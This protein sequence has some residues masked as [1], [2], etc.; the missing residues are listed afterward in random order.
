[1]SVD[2][3]LAL[4]YLKLKEWCPKYTIKYTTY[5][6]INYKNLQYRIY[7]NKSDDQLLL[8]KQIHDSIDILLEFLQ[9]NNIDYN[10]R[11][12]DPYISIESYYYKKTY[13]YTNEDLI[14]VLKQELQ[15]YPKVVNQ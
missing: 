12:S 10:S 4:V 2:N 7:T 14:E 1:M 6:I 9:L 15:L 8:F 5:I 13:Y 11:I 3:Q